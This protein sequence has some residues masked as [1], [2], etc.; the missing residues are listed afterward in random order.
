MMYSMNFVTYL[1]SASSL[2]VSIGILLC[3]LGSVY[4]QSLFH[5]LY[6]WYYFERPG[7]A[8][9]LLSKSEYEQQTKTATQKAMEDLRHYYQENPNAID[10]VRAEKEVYLQRFVRGRSH[11]ESIE[12][13]FSDDERSLIKWLSCTVQ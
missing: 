8:T 13:D 7:R 3:A 6:F 2:E 10:N 9:R 4:W 12:T 5:Q 1:C 11:L